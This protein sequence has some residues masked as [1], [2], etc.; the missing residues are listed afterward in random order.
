MGSEAKLKA[1][2]IWVKGAES[3]VVL[4]A[5]GSNGIRAV[6]EPHE[7]ESHQQWLDRQ[8]RFTTPPVASA[9]DVR[10]SDLIANGWAPDAEGREVSD[11]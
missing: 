1:G 3:F 4:W 5:D 10:L 8:P 7:Q 6:R 2:Q 11:E 9:A